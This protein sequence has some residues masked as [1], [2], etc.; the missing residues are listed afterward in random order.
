MPR[1]GVVDVQYPATG[2]AWAA[3]VVASDVH[4]STIVD[5]YVVHTGQIS[6]YEPGRFFARELPPILSVLEAGAP[7]DLLVIDGNPL[8]DI[9]CVGRVKAVLQAGRWVVPPGANVPPVT[10]KE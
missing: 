10:R 1:F 5:E 8:Q 7:V 3:L 2:G 4:L 9:A 6:P